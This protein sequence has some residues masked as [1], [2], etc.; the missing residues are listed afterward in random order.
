MPPRRLA[1]PGLA[2]SILGT[3]GGGPRYRVCG[4]RH[5]TVQRAQRRLHSIDNA[6]AEHTDLQDFTALDQSFD[7]NHGLTRVG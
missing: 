1:Y 7:A 2:G 5:A 3:A 4:G 6:P